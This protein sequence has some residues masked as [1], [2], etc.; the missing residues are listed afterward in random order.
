MA[1]GSLLSGLLFLVVVPYLARRAMP[2]PRAARKWLVIRAVVM[3]LFFLGGALTPQAP[4]GEEP[5]LWMLVLAVVGCAVVT[6]LVV[7]GLIALLARLPFG[8]RKW[9]RPTLSSFLDFLN[10]LVFIHF[11]GLIF[12]SA[13]LGR[14]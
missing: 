12:A 13:G 4:R 2:T 5:P 7:A 3:V 8:R 9:E 10:P 14:C 1:G 6:T 11:V